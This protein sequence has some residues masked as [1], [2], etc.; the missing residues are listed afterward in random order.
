MRITVV[1]QDIEI[2]VSQSDGLLFLFAS[3]VTLLLLHSLI[4]KHERKTSGLGL[5]SISLGRRS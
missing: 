3:Q 2:P 4:I 1:V 5:K